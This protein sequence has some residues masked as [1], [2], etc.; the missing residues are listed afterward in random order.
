VTGSRKFRFALLSL[1]ALV[2]G[3]GVAVLRQTSPDLFEEFV[4]GLFLLVAGFG[5]ANGIEHI[6]GAVKGRRPEAK[7]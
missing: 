7:P 3:Y 6:A 4:F 5:G 2:A 1:A